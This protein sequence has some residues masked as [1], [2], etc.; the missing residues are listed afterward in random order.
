MASIACTKDLVPEILGH[1]TPDP[2][3]DYDEALSHWHT[4]SNFAPVPTSDLQRNWEAPILDNLTNALFEK[5]TS[6]QH[7][8]RLLAAFRKESGA[9]LNA[10]PCAPLGL[11]MDDSTVRIAVGLRLG[12]PLCHPHICVCGESVDQFGTHGLCFIKKGGTFSRHS[13]LNDILRRAFSKLHVPTLLEPP[14]MFR[15]DGKRADGLTLMPWSKGRSLVW[16]ATCSDTLCKSYV[17][18][19]SR[20]AGAA[21]AKAETRKRDLYAELPSQYQFVPFAVETLGSFGD[22]ALKLV[23][24]L[25]G[26]LR[27]VS[28]DGRETSWLIQ[29]VSLAI[30]RGNAAS[31][32]A[33]IP[34]TSEYY[35]TYN[36]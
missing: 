6:T 19:T 12:T 11:A 20:N 10:L 28:G 31:V 22:D 5:A 32:L 29:R 30:Q 36:L 34:R 23:H 18:S 3:P 4:L 15:T 17:T 21:A 33:T 16:D 14:N 8:A 9:W 13:A 24:D 1:A 26:R 7:K 35:K 2:D 25:G 27:S